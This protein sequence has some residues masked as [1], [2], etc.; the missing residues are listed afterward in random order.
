C[1]RAC[2]WTGRLS[3]IQAC[4][5]IESIEKTRTF[6]AKICG[7]I[8]F[9]SQKRSFSRKSAAAVGNK[10]SGCPACPYVTIGI[11]MPRL[12][13]LQPSMRFGRLGSTK[14]MLSP[15]LDQTLVHHRVGHLQEPRDVRAVDVV[16]RRAEAVRRLDARLVNRLHDEAEAVV[17]LLAGPAVAHRVLRHLEAGAG[18]AARVRRLAGRVE[19]ARVDELLHAVEV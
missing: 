13:L 1:R 18:D 12:A 2:S 5:L 7:S 6:P 11:S 4:L 15:P 3:S 9:T 10:R 14:S 17:D 8:D 19:D 16:P